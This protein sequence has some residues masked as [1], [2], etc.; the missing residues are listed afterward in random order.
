MLIYGHRGARGEA[1]ENTLASFASALQAGVTRVELDL[2]LSADHQ[3]MVIHDP[4]LQRTTGI[5]GRV[6]AHTAEQ[7]GRMD[8]R[9]GLKGWAEP[10]PIPTLEQLFQTFPQFEHYQL[11][12]KSG[13]RG[14]ARP[15]LEAILRLVDRYRLQDK[16]VI[17]SASRHLL[18]Y[19]RDSRCPLPTGLVEEHGILD[20]VKSALR[21]ECRLDLPAR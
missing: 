13:S 3:L 20:P 11:E 6:A 21:Y 8:A 16:V 12:V 18:R 15:V 17:T 2:H 9:L 19:A 5:R 14:Q 7:L 1:P 10:C 4:T